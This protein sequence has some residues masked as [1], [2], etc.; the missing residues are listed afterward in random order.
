MRAEKNNKFVKWIIESAQSTIDI[1]ISV[2]NTPVHSPTVLGWLAKEVK[3]PDTCG[4]FAHQITENFP[5]NARYVLAGGGGGV[6]GF[7]LTGA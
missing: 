1:D 5:E 4:P 6:R 3:V 2:E 7:T